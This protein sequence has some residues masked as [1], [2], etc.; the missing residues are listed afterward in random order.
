M[1]GGHRR[2]GQIGKR[3][4]PSWLSLDIGDNLHSNYH[5]LVKTDMERAWAPGS[6]TVTYLPHRQGRSGRAGQ[7]RLSRLYLPSLQSQLSRSE[8]TVSSELP[9]PGISCTNCDSHLDSQ[10]QSRTQL[11]EFLLKWMMLIWEAVT[12]TGVQSEGGGGGLVVSSLGPSLGQVQDW[13]SGTSSHHPV[14]VH[15]E[16]R[17]Q[18]LNNPSDEHP[19]WEWLSVASLSDWILKLRKEKYPECW[20]SS[21]RPSVEH[22]LGLYHKV[23]RV[24]TTHPGQTIPVLQQTWLFLA[25]WA[26]PVSSVRKWPNVHSECAAETGYI[27]GYPHREGWQLCSDEVEKQCECV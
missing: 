24:V 20:Y 22:T 27:M 9:R 16:P 23:S 26:E 17:R 8:I 4:Q 12:A 25:S 3:S 13:T 10:L 6:A 7:H 14:P 19:K 18:E 2:A 5:P 1:G 11:F 15:H 21:S